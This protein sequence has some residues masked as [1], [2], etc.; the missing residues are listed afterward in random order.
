MSKRAL[1]IEHDHVSLGGPIWRAFEAR[2]YAIERFLVVP[3]SSYGTPNVTVTFP[4]FSQY[5]I[6]VPMGAPYGAYE[7]ER[8]GN[9]LTPEL[10]AL[11]AAHN[12]GQP[13]MGICFGGQMMARTLG[14][15]VSR[16]PAAELGW[17]EIHT[18]D[19]SL[20]SAGPWFEYHWDRWI[21]PPLATE[22]ARTGL[23][24]QAFTLGRTLALQFHPE[25]D[26][27][28]LEEWLAMDGGCAEVESE[29]VDPDELRAQTKA[30]QSKTD[31]NAFDLVNT[32]LDRIATAEVIVVD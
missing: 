6:I 17:Y 18:D 9:W 25:I 5:D 7:D 4:D 23:A 14:G 15:S 28:V 27:E 11:K 30:L 26:S 31:Q 16:A 8:I 19:P 10:A 22:I 2:G 21:S 29:G 32:F 12:A 24:V 20:I 1:F 13:I 3:E